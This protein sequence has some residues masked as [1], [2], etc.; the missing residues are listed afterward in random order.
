MQ[1][2]NIKDYDFPFPKRFT[3]IQKEYLDELRDEFGGRLETDETFRGQYESDYNQ[4]QIKKFIKNYK[5]I[6]YN[7]LYSYLSNFENTGTDYEKEYIKLFGIKKK[8]KK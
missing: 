1:K 5:S 4:K 6:P 3:K 2:L 8:S 7:A